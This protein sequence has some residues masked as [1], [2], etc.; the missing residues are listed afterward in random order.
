[1]KY[2]WV[3]LISL[4]LVITSSWIKR[5]IAVALCGILGFNSNACFWAQQNRA[6]AIQPP[7]YNLAQGIDIFRNDGEA[8]PPQSGDIDIFRN[9]G[10]S[11]PP[12]PAPSAPGG[13]DIFRN[14]DVN[15]PNSPIPQP[16]IPNTPQSQVEEESLDGIWLYSMYTSPSVDSMLLRTPIRITQTADD[17]IIE[18]CENDCG[19]FEISE[20]YFKEKELQPESLVI[21]DNFFYTE[22]TESID[23]SLLLGDM[24]SIDSDNHLY[25]AIEKIAS[26]TSQNKNTQKT[27]NQ[28]TESTYLN[29]STG[30]TSNELDR[31]FKI[32]SACPN[33][34]ALIGKGKEFYKK[35]SQETIQRNRAMKEVAK[36][37]ERGGQELARR[38]IAS[39]TYHRNSIE[40][41]SRWLNDPFKN[42]LRDPPLRPFKESINNV[43]YNKTLSNCL[44]RQ[45]SRSSKSIN[46]RLLGRVGLRGARLGLRVLGR[47]ALPLLLLDLALTAYEFCVANPETCERIGQNIAQGLER[48]G[49]LFKGSSYGDPHLVT[50]DGFRYSFQTVGEFILAKS[51]GG[52]FEVQT[53]QGAI[54][55]RDVSLNTGAAMKIGRDRIAFYSKFFPDSDT[56]TPL[57]V[58]G[59]PTR[60]SGNS[61]SLPGGGAIYK[62][63]GRNYLVKWPSGEEVAIRFI[64][65]SGSEYM[66]VTP[67]VLSSP[68]GQFTGLLGNLNG[69]PGD[70][71]RTRNGNVLPSKSSYGQVRDVVTRIVPIPGA[72]PV[73]RIENAVFNQ[74]YK[75][76]GNSWRIS[77]SES[78]FDYAPGQTTETFTDKSF[79][80]RY[81]TMDMLSAQQIRE[82]EQTC[83][84]AGVEPDLLEGCIFD[85]GFTGDR[86]FAQA[87]ASA[88]NIIDQ[89]ND[90]VPGGVPIPR[91]R[92]PIPI[93]GLP[94]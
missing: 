85:V 3:T 7:A 69:N 90:I 4:V 55:G 82:A 48:F 93:P 92:L 2:L 13:I 19:D 75:N 41:F 25:F 47:L 16:E 1:M 12:P 77:Q 22:T 80:K 81:K 88:L 38:K 36:D 21:E 43:K 26:F 44:V 86:S 42:P 94:F 72:I 65:M 8:P 67:H 89:L 74:L 52:D 17:L 30:E 54:P 51:V 58:N 6:V 45:L 91:P 59:R 33:I 46:L 20:N 70:D 5:S 23:S 39:D 83:L 29:Y 14:P 63:G 56:S 28:L 24:K 84:E 71:L 31:N 18:L 68:P 53:R 27:L 76:F 9:D 34:N 10:G 40:E 49:S 57:R 15:Q 78:L 64:Q 60:I 32:A 50:F 73:R 66:N 11:S 79:P 35:V 37:Q 61:L 62:Q 87:A